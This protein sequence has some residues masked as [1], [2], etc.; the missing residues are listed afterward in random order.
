MAHHDAEISEVVV[1]LRACEG[2]QFVESVRKLEALGLEVDEIIEDECV[3]NGEIET[4]KVAA[5]QKL[6]NVSAVRTVMTYIADYPLG[7]PRDK[8]L[9]DDDEDAAEA[10]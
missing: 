8:D 1:V 9:V 4:S 3:V 2:A 5:L 10:V 6:E 7:D